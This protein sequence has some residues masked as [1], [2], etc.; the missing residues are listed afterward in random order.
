MSH[1]RAKEVRKETKEFLLDRDER[2]RE[3]ITTSSWKSVGVS[4]FVM[5]HK[6]DDSRHADP[7]PPT[8]YDKNEK[9]R[10]FAFLPAKEVSSQGRESSA[11]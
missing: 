9:H 7:N 2:G 5:S 1:S 8:T 3:E 6:L 10:I 11:A 4:Q